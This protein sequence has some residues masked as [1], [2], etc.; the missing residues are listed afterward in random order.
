MKTRGAIMAYGNY[1][2]CASLAF[3]VKIY[4]KK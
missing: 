3:F 2:V 1:S 4:Y